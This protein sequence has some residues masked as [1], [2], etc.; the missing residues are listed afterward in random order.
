M[1]YSTRDNKHLSKEKQVKI[2]EE[3]VL[4]VSVFHPPASSDSS[5]DSILVGFLRKATLLKPSILLCATDRTSIRIDHIWNQKRS[6]NTRELP[7]RVQSD[8]QRQS[9]SERNGTRGQHWPQVTTDSPESIWMYYSAMSTRLLWHRCVSISSA[10]LQC[11]T[12]G[13]GSCL[14]PAQF[15]Y[16]LWEMHTEVSTLL[17]RNSLVSNYFPTTYWNTQVN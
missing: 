17:W 1:T 16:K 4:E 11:H 3:K 10:L 6:E 5:L 9:T 2:H 13:G 7:L 8:D 14:S 12:G 15:P